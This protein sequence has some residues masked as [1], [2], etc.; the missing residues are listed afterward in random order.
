MFY[1]LLFKERKSPLD[2]FMDAWKDGKCTMW[3]PQDPPSP[4]FNLDRLEN[5]D[6]DS[7]HIANVGNM[8]YDEIVVLLT[9]FI[10]VTNAVAGETW[11]SDILEFAVEWIK[12]EYP[13]GLPMELISDADAMNNDHDDLG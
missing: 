6:W 11:W 2:L 13:L 12:K 10:E 7:G 4:E 8:S 5:F 1:L 9:V 3:V